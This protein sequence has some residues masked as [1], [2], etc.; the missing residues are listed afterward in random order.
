VII[1]EL[2]SPTN[3]IGKMCFQ[4]T[5][6]V[7]KYLLTASSLPLN[8]NINI[9]NLYIIQTH[10]LSYTIPVHPVLRTLCGNFLHSLSEQKRL[11]TYTVFQVLYILLKCSLS[12]Y[13]H[14]IKNDDHLFQRLP[15]F[16]SLSLGLPTPRY[17]ITNE[18]LFMT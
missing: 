13:A 16:F 12:D 11:E 15:N 2:Y 3:E 17:T 6:E 18:L 14:S 8:L 1:K 4:D 7:I 9:E 5:N 10:L